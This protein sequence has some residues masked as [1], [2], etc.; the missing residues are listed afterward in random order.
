MPIDRAAA[1]TFIW[2][3]ARLLDRH[4]YAMLFEGG[5]AEPVIEALAAYQNPDGSWGGFVPIHSLALAAAWACGDRGDRVRSGVAWLRSRIVHGADGDA[6]LGRPVFWR[7]SAAQTA[8]LRADFD[9]LVGM[10]ALGHIEALTAHRGTWLQVRP[11]AAHGR[12]R[13]RAY[14]PEGEYLDTI[15]RGFYLR[16]RFTGALLRDPTALPGVE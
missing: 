12:V 13:T 7:P 5:P 9:D 2:S 11:K 6:T 16:A 10:I 14:G 4:R 8:V 1:E 3:T 15:P